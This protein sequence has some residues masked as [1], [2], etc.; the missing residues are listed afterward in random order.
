MIGI[1]TNILVRYLVDDDSAQRKKAAQFLKTL[2]PSDKGYICLVTFVETIW[3]LKSV[4]HIKQEQIVEQLLVLLEAPQLSFQNREAL[5]SV[6]SSDLSKADIAD[7][8]I[9]RLSLTAG[10]SETKTFDK[11]AARLDGMTLL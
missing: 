6:L 4:Y 1:D 5:I 11:K 2:S 10:C 8:I 9:N 3:V 7:A